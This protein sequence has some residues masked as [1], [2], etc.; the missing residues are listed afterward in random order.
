MNEFVLLTLR[1]AS[2]VKENEKELT[3]EWTV[4]V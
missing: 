3:L 2:N 4:I 1:S